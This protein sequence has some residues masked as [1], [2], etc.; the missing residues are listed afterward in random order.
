MS[1]ATARVA[2]GEGWR[3]HDVICTHGPAD[4]AFE[5]RHAWV[6][7]AAVTGGTFQ[8]RT[9]SGAATLVPGALLLGDAETCYECGHEHAR[10]D[11][12]LAFHF[13]P[14]SF[15]RLAAEMPGVLRT[16]FTRASVPPLP[17]LL[18]L[19]AEAEAARDDGDACAFEELGLRLAAAA[20]I[21]QDRGTLPREAASSRDA[22][23]IE[24][25]GRRIA[26]APDTPL[27]LTSLA[28]EARISRYRFLRAFRQIVGVTP[29]QYLLRMRLQVAAARLRRAS[30][31]I[32]SIAYGAGFNDLSTFNRRFRRI[33]GMT[34]REWRSRR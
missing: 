27:T 15:E 30:D 1:I 20:L 34:P 32:T 13:D 17:Q 18:P 4:R 8:Y 10:G 26:A 19:I 3:V 9:Q 23:R 16:A 24:Q 5:E 2:S 11:R 29:Y 12:C 21:L 22:R 28:N 31:S 25:A 33:M 14:A 6:S 7:I